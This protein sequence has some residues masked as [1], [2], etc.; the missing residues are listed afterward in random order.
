MDTS[1]ALD[2]ARPEN[3]KAMVEATRKY[4]NYQ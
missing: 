4:G 3:V 2:E 1:A